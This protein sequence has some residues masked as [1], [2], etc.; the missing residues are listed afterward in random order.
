MLNRSSHMR[1]LFFQIVLFLAGSAIGVFAQYIHTDE[2]KK[3]ARVLAVLL[4]ATALVWA[5]YELAKR[6]STTLPIPTAVPSREPTDAAPSPIP[7]TSAT[8]TYAPTPAPTSTI[9]PS[10]V[11]FDGFEDGGQP[12]DRW[13]SLHPYSNLDSCSAQ[14]ANGIL[15]LACK[16]SSTDR[17][18]EYS[19]RTT[20]SKVV[21]AVAMSARVDSHHDLG[22]VSLKVHFRGPEGTRSIRAYSVVLQID[23]GYVVEHYPDEGWRGEQLAEFTVPS[24]QEHVLQLDYAT[25]TPQFYLD[26]SLIE[27]Q[28]QPTLPPNSTWQDWSFDG[29]VAG[30]EGD[31]GELRAQIDWVATRPLFVTST[32]EPTPTSTDL[33]AIGPSEGMYDIVWNPACWRS[34]SYEFEGDTF[35]YQMDTDIISVKAGGSR[36]GH[37]LAGDLEVRTHPYVPCIKFDVIETEIAVD[38]VAG[39]MHMQLQSGW[40]GGDV[41]V[42]IGLNKDN[43]TI[44]LIWTD[45]GTTV[46]RAEQLSGSGFHSL[47]L[48]WQNQ[49]VIVLVDGQRRF[50]DVS[51]PADD[52][53]GWLKLNAVYSGYG[54]ISARI[55]KVRI[56]CY[57]QRK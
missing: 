18:L 6:E 42:G 16:G 29:F 5:G 35:D 12:G 30:S 8:P 21:D 39:S 41:A 55:K 37:Y 27:L 14:Q 33:C 32:G 47:R 46:V 7:T 19:P 36:G 38:D 45:Y 56:E 22:W 25:G 34:E 10:Y 20:D 3:L 49:Q 13:S 48:E 50:T 57:P 4:I 9:P 23:R 17:F 52:Y 11:L 2:Q 31:P 28:A 26:G 24:S 43:P 40:G 54:Q 1:D 51:L 15:H 53:P 44:E